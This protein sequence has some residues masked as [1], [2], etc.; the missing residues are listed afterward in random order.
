[1]LS[2]GTFRTYLSILLGHTT[3]AWHSPLEWS[4]YL[5]YENFKKVHSQPMISSAECKTGFGK[6]MKTLPVKI[7]L[8]SRKA[9]ID[10]F[11]K[12][13]RNQQISRVLI[14]HFLKILVIW[15]CLTKFPITCHRQRMES[16]SNDNRLD[17]LV[18]SQAL[19]WY[20]IR[21]FKC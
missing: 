5:R 16:L 3:V 10:D 2:Y 15:S 17:G 21:V 7:F 8:G 19:I 20:I 6:P 14:T 9:K 4:A 12:L 1:M 11:M 13:L 18:T